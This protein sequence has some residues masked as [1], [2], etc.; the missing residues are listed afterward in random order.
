[1]EF[2][3]APSPSLEPDGGSVGEAKGDLPPPL[4]CPRGCGK[5]SLG[6][7]LEGGPVLLLRKG[8]VPSGSLLLTQAS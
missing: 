5:D 1:M 8:R 6:V 4:L 7:E 2:M 3:S